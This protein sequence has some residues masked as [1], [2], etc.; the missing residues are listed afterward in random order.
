MFCSKTFAPIIVHSNKWIASQLKIMISQPKRRIHNVC[1]S[2]NR[3]MKQ[4]F[5]LHKEKVTG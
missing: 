5:R 3:V 2:V 4:K 1:V